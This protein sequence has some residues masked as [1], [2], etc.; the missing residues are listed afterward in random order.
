M[1]K[2]VSSRA[3][4][5]RQC[6]ETWREY[7]KE[8][9]DQYHRMFEF[10][11]GKQWLDE[12]A[13]ALKSYKKIP[14]SFNKM[15]TL[16]N[17]LLGEQQQNTPQLQVQPMEDCDEKVAELRERLTKDIMFK[18]NAKRARQT[19]AKQSA[20]G[21]F[22][23]YAIITDYINESSFDQYILYI[24]FKDA[25]RC[26]WDVSA[27]EENKT[28][29]MYCGWLSRMSRKKLRDIYGANIEKRIKSD[30]EI[31][32][33]EEQEL[34][35]YENQGDYNLGYVW[36]DDQSVTI[37]HHFR[38][39]T[40][41][42]TKYKLSNGRE[43]NEDE[44]QKIIAQSK[45]INAEKQ[46]M[47]EMEIGQ[48]YLPA[49][50]MQPGQQVPQA[51]MQMQPQAQMGE[52]ASPDN[53]QNLMGFGDNMP[54]QMQDDRLSLYDNGEPVRIE[55]QKEVRKHKIVY[56]QFCGDY[57]LDETECMTSQLP[58]PFVDQNSWY[59][60][61]GKQHCRPFFVDAVDAQRYINYLGT[62]SAYTLKVS[63]YDQFMG[64]KENVQSQDTQAVWRDPLQVQGILTYD[65]ARDGSR[66][67]RIN[68]PELSQSLLT[69]YER[70]IEDLYTSTGLYPSRMG[71]AGGEVSGKAIDA[72]TRQGSY[73]TYTFFNS[74]NNAIAKDGEIV[75]EL[76]PHVYDSQRVISLMDS[77]G[78][79]ESI[80][81][82]QAMDDY[83]EQIKNDIRKGTYEVKLLPGPSY[84]GQKEQAMEALTQILQANPQA[85]PMIADLFAENLPLANTI[86]LKNR[87]K[88]LVPPE[89]LEA[90]K[91]GETPP[92]QPQAPDPTAQLAQMQL[93]LKM[94]DLALKEK[95]L[96]LK[97]QKQQDELQL[98]MQRLEADRA[99][100]AAGMQK[101]EMT[102]LQETHRTNTD[103]EIAHYDNLTKLLTTNKQGE[104]NQ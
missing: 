100:V 30:K 13:N 53:E 75:N 44:L 38:R 102:Y 33:G 12:E 32:G 41:T 14:M 49:P 48:E 8:N 51:Q 74:I 79:P 81:V 69:Q 45:K 37:Q 103:A 65:S 101:D 68:P 64:S 50:E 54:A 67:E 34:S 76:I 20:I 2:K 25:T 73:P 15:G 80:T 29:G 42:E 88:T 71:Q 5:A 11:Y 40:Y 70:A 4:T 28:D 72:R 90:G 31:N 91:T 3:K 46:L 87:L 55:K 99:E 66:P 47:Q 26:Y 92:Q 61:S 77:N 27:E 98:E 78:K 18:S 16:A 6:A 82:N 17:T 19:A 95:D 59:D 9:I 97:A 104:S 63:R 21:G 43:V 7:F 86:E 83:G 94:K 62:Q 36:A 24:S 52:I 84:E 89:I 93:Q 96:M 23:G 85:F 1:S 22:G 60:K 57:L 58:M 10:T 35:L 39:K 56:E